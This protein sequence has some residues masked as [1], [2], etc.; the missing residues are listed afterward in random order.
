M[1]LWMIKKHGVVYSSIYVISS[2]LINI[3]HAEEVKMT[4]AS[5][6]KR[7]KQTWWEEH[8]QAASD[9][10]PVQFLRESKK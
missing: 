5:F 9:G 6:T 2:K 1:A 7:K 3:T 4:F 10:L 8:A